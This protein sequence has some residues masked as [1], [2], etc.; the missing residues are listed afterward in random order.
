MRGAVVAVGAALLVVLA[1]AM[2]AGA[3]PPSEGKPSSRTPAWLT[4]PAGDVPGGFHT[5]AELYEYQGRLNATAAKI[6]AVDPA[7]PGVVADPTS[8]ELRV[9]WHGAVPARVSEIAR[10]AGVPVK[11]LPA[12]HRHGDLVA[13]ARRLSA[14]PRAAGVSP[15]ADGSG[16]DLKVT[17]VQRPAG[18]ADLFASARVPLRVTVGQ[19]PAATLG[20][21]ADTP[22][23]WG[24]SRYYWIGSGVYSACTNGFAIA[25]PGQANRYMITAAHCGIEN[26]AIY[27][28]GQGFPTGVMGFRPIC[29]DTA[30]INY[31]GGVSAAIYTGAWNSVTSVLVGG[32]ASD[33]V[34][35]F[36]NT[37]GATTGEHGGIQVNTVDHFTPVTGS[38]CPGSVGPLNIATSTTG[39]CVTM[40]GDSGGPVYYYSGGRAIGVGTI[41]AGLNS[42]YCP[43]VDPSICPGPSCFGYSTVYYAPLLRAVGGIYAGSLTYYGVNILTL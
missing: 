23:F 1:S 25:F 35:N 38:P 26:G 30:L 4:K 27:I 24:G 3:V 13:E 6:Q 2:P 29:R 8:R 39:G 17:T 21:P 41:S 12:A 9:Y 37:G 10:S 28:Q 15:R 36:V 19:R 14:D 33:Y 18:K 20:R 34:G 43:S 32:A 40:A 22:R 42:A 7:N 11:I 16:L 5:W 31:P